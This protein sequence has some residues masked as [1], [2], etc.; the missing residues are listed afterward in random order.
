M[1]AGLLVP[2]GAQR[3]GEPLI[4]AGGAAGCGAPEP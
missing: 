1:L 4:A 2:L 3:A